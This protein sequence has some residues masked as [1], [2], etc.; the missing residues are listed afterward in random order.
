MHRTAVIAQFFEQTCNRR[1]DTCM[2]AC[3]T[4]A[5]A[6]LCMMTN[7][8]GHLFK[9][10]SKRVTS[11]CIICHTIA[12]SSRPNF[13]EVTNRR[14]T[15]SAERYTLASQV[16]WSGSCSGVYTLGFTYERT[17]AVYRRRSQTMLGS[18]WV[19]LRFFCCLFREEQ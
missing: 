18:A 6:L 16:Q 17:K 10:H 13:K 2:M 9:F 1:P 3:C 8:R 14:L 19:G 15:K 5:Y 12:I 7:G 4:L 11:I